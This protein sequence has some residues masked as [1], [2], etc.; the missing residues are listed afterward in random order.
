MSSTLP[1]HADVIIIGGGI[2]GIGAACQIVQKM[3]GLSYIILEARENIGGTWDFY[4]FPGM[5]T[6]SDMYT[7]AYSF[8]PWSD[9]KSSASA[10]KVLAY[11]V[12][13]AEKHDVKRHVRLNERVS[14]AKWNSGRNEWTVTSNCKGKTHQFTS[15]YMFM[16]AGFSDFSKVYTP[17]FKDANLFQG[18]VVNPQMWPSDLEVKDKEILVIG[19]GATAVTIVPALAETAGHV[20][21][22]QRSPTYIYQT[23]NLDPIAAFCSKYLPASWTV[24]LMRAKFIFEQQM[25]YIVAKTFPDFLK[26]LLIGG[27]RRELGRNYDIKTHF[28]PKYNVLQQRL[29]LSPD[30]AFTKCITDRG[31]TVVTDSVE[32]FNATGVVLAS[33]QELKADII[34]TAT[35]FNLQA[36]GGIEIEVDGVSYSDMTKSCMYKGV[37]LCGVPN[38]IVA[39]G[40]LT[41]SWTLRVDLVFSY[42]MRLLK[43]M[44]SRH[45]RTFQASFPPESMPKS[46]IF[47]IFTSTYLDRNKRAFYHCGT[48]YP[49]VYNSNYYL[50][51]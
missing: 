44:H 23:A 29:C 11:L 33:G 48:E 2:S 40:Y 47:G 22:L 50:D 4:K 34:V 6:D 32:R 45:L 46:S 28:T 24:K 36:L 26:R 37:M 30:F 3:P 49:F 21:M 5:R 19:S 10:E 14:T 8:N 42:A 12:E 17:D 27:I 41:A 20:T 31:V 18:T 43:Y 15:T 7:M 51:W 16:C 9:N 39:L 35:G 1:E 38:M 13:T 25:V